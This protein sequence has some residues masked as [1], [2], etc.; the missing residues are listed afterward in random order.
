MARDLTKGNITSLILRLSLPVTGSMLLRIT[1]TTVD[2]AF[3]GQLGADAVASVALASSFLFICFGISGAFNRV[4]I[5]FFSHAIGAGDYK[6]A[7][8]WLLRGIVMAL[9]YGLAASIVLYIF[10]VRL[11]GFLVSDTELIEL[12]SQYLAFV[13]WAPLFHV[14]QVTLNGALR[15]DGD[16]DTGFKIVVFGNGLNIVLDLILIFGMLGFPAMGVRGAGLASLICR[17]LTCL[18][19]FFLFFRGFGHYHITLKNAHGLLDRMEFK[20]FFRLFLPLAGEGILRGFN[21]FFIMKI[22]SPFGAVGVTAYAV[23]DRIFNIFGI[24][25][26]GI[27]SS[28]AAIAG[29]CLGAGD[30]KRAW[31]TLINANGL[32]FVWAVIGII[33]FLTIPGHILSIF[34]KDQSAITTAIPFLRI[35]SL[36]LVFAGGIYISMNVMIAAGNSIYPVITALLGNYVFQLP[37]AFALSRYTPLQL[38]GVFVADVITH[39]AQ[40]AIFFIFFYAGKVKSMGSPDLS[41]SQGE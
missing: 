33:C 25:G 21:K 1:Y 23:C 15:A 19:Y 24:A 28:T 26:N 9:C 8:R 39:V 17:T 35:L 11:I 12:G 22:L 36:S 41:E 7:N 20:D 13:A 40:F 37:F 16:T 34:I 10:R 31:R 18:V 5:H 3:L 38:S 2:L 27:A 32:Y 14:V 30:R 6:R 29:Q 4:M